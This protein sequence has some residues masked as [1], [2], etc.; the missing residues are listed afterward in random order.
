MFSSSFSW[1]VPDT[2]GSG[3]VGDPA[4]LIA[5]DWVQFDLVRFG[6]VQFGSV[7]FLDLEGST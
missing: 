3:V 4:G 1:G 5:V 2:L 7:R 6:S